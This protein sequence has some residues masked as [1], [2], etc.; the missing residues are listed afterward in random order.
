MTSNGDLP[1]LWRIF[2]RM[3]EQ[4]YMQNELSG[5]V[6]GNV[7]QA[8]AVHGDVVFQSPAQGPAPRYVEIYERLADRADAQ[9]RAEDAAASAAAD[10]RA[11]RR[12]V[13]FRRKKICFWLFWSC[14]VTGAAWLKLGDA[15]GESAISVAFVG[16]MTTGLFFLGYAG[17]K[18]E[19]HYERPYPWFSSR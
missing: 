17:A 12:K 9:V 3:G 13:L 2:R 8:G 19:L 11:K 10:A 18:Y 7:V 14:M 16:F 15:R 6:G 1:M 4:P 5:N